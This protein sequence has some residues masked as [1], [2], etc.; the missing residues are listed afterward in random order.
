M[1]WRM[2]EGVERGNRSECLNQGRSVSKSRS[3][4][5]HGSGSD[6]HRP[7]RSG[8]KLGVPEVGRLLACA[9]HANRAEKFSS[10]ENVETFLI[11]DVQQL[12]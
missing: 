7:S 6:R 9:S 5:G 3:P 12:Q 11:D 2:A 8:D 1:G 4:S 10:A